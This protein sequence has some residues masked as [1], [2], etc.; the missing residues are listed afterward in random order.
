MIKIWK[1]ILA[2][3]STIPKAEAIYNNQP[4]GVPIELEDNNVIEDTS[5]YIITWEITYVLSSLGE[6]SILNTLFVILNYLYSFIVINNWFI[7][8]D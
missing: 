8:C 6:V 1:P 5:D 4:I 7:G 3:C 2:M